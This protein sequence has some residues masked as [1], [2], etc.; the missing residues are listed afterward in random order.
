[1]KHVNEAKKRLAEGKSHEALEI[2][3]NLLDLAPQNQEALRIKAQILDAHGRFDESLVVLRDLSRQDGISDEALRELEKRS[4]E[5]REVSIY[6]EITPEGRWYYAFPSIQVW[7]SL[8]GF[9][10][11][12]L[13]LLLSPGLLGQGGNGSMIGIVFSFLVFVAL[14][15]ILLMVV[16]TVGIKKILVGISGIKVCTRFKETAIAW[17]SV[18]AVVLEHNP[19]IRAGEL[20]LVLYGAKETN[21]SPQE[22]G[23]VIPL[24]DSS[25]GGLVPLLRMNVSEKK[26]VV[27]A[28]RHFVRSILSY[29]DSVSYVA[30][31]PS[32]HIGVSHSPQ[33]KPF[34]I[35]SEGPAGQRKAD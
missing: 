20:F 25:G 4:Y 35:M 7:I 18:R 1:M 6:S 34:S 19:D 11:C 23:S 21:A 26:S 29:V 30:L 15:W 16:H 28:R 2:L 13:F 12:A 14:P 3:L 9:V 24:P 22:L 17:E 33:E 5:E 27:R 31:E 8:Y 32:S 10:G